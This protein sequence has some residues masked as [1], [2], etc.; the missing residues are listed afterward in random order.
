MIIQK[1]NGS[2]LEIQ[3]EKPEDLELIK[4]MCRNISSHDSTQDCH[5]DFG[6]RQT[7]VARAMLAE[8]DRK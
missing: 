2:R 7:H 1:K 4:E 6:Q 5:V 3:W 8:L